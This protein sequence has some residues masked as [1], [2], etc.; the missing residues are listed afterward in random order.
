MYSFP[1]QNN[2]KLSS[3]V[4]Y[5]LQKAE[6]KSM[7]AQ[8]IEKDRE[9][10]FALKL[11]KELNDKYQK[12]LKELEM[13][14]KTQSKGPLPVVSEYSIYDEAESSSHKMISIIKKE[15]SKESSSKNSST[16][17][18][19]ILPSSRTNSLQNGRANS[20]TNLNKPKTQK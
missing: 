14:K 16:Q 15:T 17:K 1:F 11:K 6:I 18:S 7:E 20:M 9:I 5:D 3:E 19:L 2:I 13:Y 4:S 8:I 12:S 10:Q